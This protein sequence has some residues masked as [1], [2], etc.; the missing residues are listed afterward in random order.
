MKTSKSDGLNLRELKENIEFTI[1]N[2]KE[3]Q[4][5]EDIPVLITLSESSVG[6]RAST[7]ISC[8]GMGID[9]EHGQFRIEPARAVVGKGNTLQDAKE[10]HCK[11]Y[12]NRNYYFC[13]RCE[14]KISKNDKFCRYCGQKLK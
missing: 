12:D 5:A 2:L 3:Y 11:K 1:K 8:V 7:N 9:W 10:I 4:K 13:P 6:A 14:G